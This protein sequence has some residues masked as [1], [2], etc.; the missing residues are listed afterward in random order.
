MELLLVVGGGGGDK[1]KIPRQI[2][3]QYFLV[4][5]LLNA[6]KTEFNEVQHIVAL[7]V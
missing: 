1:N 7:E 3:F 4:D 2:E 6:F 5:C